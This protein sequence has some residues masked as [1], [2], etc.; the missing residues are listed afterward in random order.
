M[1]AAPKEM[2]LVI[3][4]SNF[5][6]GNGFQG[7]LVIGTYVDEDGNTCSASSSLGNR[8]AILGVVREWLNKADSYDEGFNSEEGRYDAMVL[9]QIHQQ[10]ERTH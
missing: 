2:K 7:A 3:D 9:R 8:H 4:A 10:N 5:L 6:S 1:N